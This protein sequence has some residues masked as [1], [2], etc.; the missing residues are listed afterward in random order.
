[1]TDETLRPL[2]SASESRQAR[3]RALRV[4]VDREPIVT[5]RGA[6]LELLSPP[7]ATS[8]DA[9]ELERDPVRYTETLLAQQGLVARP[10]LRDPGTERVEV[11]TT[12]R[13]AVQGAVAVAALA[14]LAGFWGYWLYGLLFAAAGVAGV[15]AVA[16]GF[17]TLRGW[18]PS[19]LPSGRLL[20][21][22]TTLAFLLLVTVAGVLPIR[23]HRIDIGRAQTLVVQADK[24]IDQNKFTEAEANL[25]AAERLVTHPPLIDD[26]R[27][28]LVVAQV[29]DELAK[30]TRTINKRL[31]RLV[32]AKP[33]AGNGR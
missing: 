33:R 24:L 13:F 30:R 9:D 22:V 19:W 29:R 32:P 18:A 4:R 27:A 2:A 15:L 1:V 11:S 7:P 3:V 26:V 25:F 16:L 21:A 8:E 10:S 12:P 31:R 5:E 28:H 23:S 14:T 6:L 20:G 17:E